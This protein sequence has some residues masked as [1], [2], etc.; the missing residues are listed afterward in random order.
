MEDL[1]KFI[2]ILNNR[3]Y[4]E[5]YKLYNIIIMQLKERN[6]HLP[7]ILESKKYPIYKDLEQLKEYSV[8]N[9]TDVHTSILEIIN[10]LFMYYSTKQKIIADYSNANNILSDYR[11]KSNVRELGDTDLSIDSLKP[12]VYDNNNTGKKDIGFIAHELQE[13]FPFLVNGEKDGE[14][15]Q[16]V[17][18]N[19]FI[20][21]LVRELQVLKKK[22]AQLENPNHV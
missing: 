19:G 17:N 16:S 9:I 6:I 15:I 5:Y 1:A 3:M 14:I 12:V 22:V 21:L 18:Y 11:I 8:E 2:T 20:G 13:H 4:G 7:S 10:E